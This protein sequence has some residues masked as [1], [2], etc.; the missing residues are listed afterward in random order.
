[1]ADDGF[2]EIQ[3]N[4]KQLVFL[5]MATTIVAV[6]IFLCGVMVG[7]GVRTATASTTT[8]APPAPPTPEAAPP[9]DSQTQATTAGA[10]EKVAAAANPPT[11]LPP[12]PPPTSEE[13]PAPGSAKSGAAP[14][15]ADG[16][17][18]PRAANEPASRADPAPSAEQAGEGWIVQVAALG[19]QAEADTI[20][21]RLKSKGYAAY[22]LPPPSGGGMY[23]VRVGKFKERRD[24]ENVMR[25]LQKEEH[26]KPW[27]TR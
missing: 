16:A 2:R 3:L 11:A 6:V 21:Q 5:F 12:A 19:K 17:A 26:F 9:G 4:G 24:A 27:I 25:R 18:A 10:A 22:L 20:V 13:S 1:M 14:P 8:E 7:R 15:P 23:R